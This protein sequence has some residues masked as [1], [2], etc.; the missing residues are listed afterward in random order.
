MPTEPLSR[1]SSLSIQSNSGSKQLPQPG[2]PSRRT[3]LE[4]VKDTLERRTK[5]Q[6]AIKDNQEEDDVSSL[7]SPRVGFYQ[8]SHESGQDKLSRLSVQKLPSVSIATQRVDRPL[9]H[10]ISVQSPSIVADRVPVD[11]PPSVS[12][13]EPVLPVDNGLVVNNRFDNVDIQPDDV[14]RLVS[15]IL[16]SQL[17]LAVDSFDCFQQETKKRE[18]GTVTSSRQCQVNTPKRWATV[19]EEDEH[20]PGDE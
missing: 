2:S 4:A 13:N 17:Q 3:L 15:D 10:V 8:F 9:N 19:A 16:A 7:P 14:A 20:Y 6:P 5:S 12:Q 18:P 1:P 11:S